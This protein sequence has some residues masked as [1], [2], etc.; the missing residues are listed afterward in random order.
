MKTMLLATP[1]AI[2]LFVYIIGPPFVDAQTPQQTCTGGTISYE[3]N[4][5]THSG[6]G[7]TLQE[8]RENALAT[9]PGVPACP[10]CPS[11]AHNCLQTRSTSGA[12][13]SE[14]Q[15]GP[16]GGIYTVQLTYRPTV[17]LDQTCDC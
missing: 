8:A 7:A 13:L 14:I 15:S 11:P 12:P 17:T 4:P 1:V 3:M 5:D 9:W 6:T 2:S 10:E 16:V